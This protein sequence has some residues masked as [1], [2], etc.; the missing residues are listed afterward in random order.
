MIMEEKCIG[1]EGKNVRLLSYPRHMQLFPKPCL[2][3]LRDAPLSGAH[4]VCEPRRPRPGVRVHFY[5]STASGG[6]TRPRRS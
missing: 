5:I 6:P 2:H 3:P 1:E 4:P